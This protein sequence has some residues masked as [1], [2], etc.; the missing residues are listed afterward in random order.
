M[1]ANSAYALTEE[2]KREFDMIYEHLELKKGTF[3]VVF[4]RLTDSTEIRKF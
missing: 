1:D 3:I 4:F 2:N